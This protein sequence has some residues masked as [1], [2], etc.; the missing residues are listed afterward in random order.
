MKKAWYDT[1]MHKN[2]LSLVKMKFPCM[3]IEHF[4][5]K[6]F[7]GDHSMH[8]VV[9]SPTT[10]EHFWGE[11]FVFMREIFIFMHGI[12]IFL[13]MRMKFSCMKFSCHDFFM[14]EFFCMFQH[15]QEE[16]AT[17]LIYMSMVGRRKVV[18]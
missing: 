3:K 14:N 1:F 9:Y 17:F 16:A 7:M 13:C 8:D 15:R 4:T 11:I 10:H 12:F 6:T 2:S 5:Q 18:H